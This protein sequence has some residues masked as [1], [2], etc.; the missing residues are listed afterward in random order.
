[1]LGGAPFLMAPLHVA[2]VEAG[3]VPVY[4]FSE[5]VSTETIDGNGNTIKTSTFA[6]KGF[7]G[8]Y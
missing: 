4:A 6:H 8:G 5:R 2:L 7:V 3:F 1:M